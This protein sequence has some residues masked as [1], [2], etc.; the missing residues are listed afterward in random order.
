M[1]MSAED[2]VEAA[3]RGLAAGEAITIPSLP[4]IAAWQ[5]LV[6]DRMRMMPGLSL[7]RPAARYGLDEAVPA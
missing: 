6:D 5:A 3:L 1:V 4:D 2:L 7:S